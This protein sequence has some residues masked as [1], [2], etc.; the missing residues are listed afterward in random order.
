M[1]T[2]FPERSCSTND[3]ERDFDLNQSH[4]VPETE[5]ASVGPIAESPVL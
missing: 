2:G 4:R 1:D 3:L 5:R